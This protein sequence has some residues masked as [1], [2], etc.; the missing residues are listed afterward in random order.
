MAEEIPQSVRNEIFEQRQGGAQNAL[1]IHIAEGKTVIL[2]EKQ[3]E[4]RRREMETARAVSEAPQS[5]DSSEK[6]V[7]TSL[8]NAGSVALHETTEIPTPSAETEISPESEAKLD[9]FVHTGVSAIHTW[10]R[11]R[12]FQDGEIPHHSSRINGGFNAIWDDRLGNMRVAD[13][14][15]LTGGPIR[16]DER[17]KFRKTTEVVSSIEPPAEIKGRLVATLDTEDVKIVRYQDC[18]DTYDYPY[19]K[20]RA[21]GTLEFGI[22]LPTKQADELL[23]LIRTEPK[24]IR[25]LVERCGTEKLGFSRDWEEH[26]QSPPYSEWRETNTGRMYMQISTQDQ[27]DSRLAPVAGQGEVLE[28]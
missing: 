20:G 18:G 16:Q 4:E 23:Q 21:G 28:V 27:L 15:S 2:T 9:K 12:T 1:N 17:R 10:V 19:G 25:R 22:A 6:P 13:A 3:V 8:A 14:I 24:T 26:E 5:L 7:E 11:S